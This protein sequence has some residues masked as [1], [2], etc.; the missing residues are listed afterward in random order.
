[1]HVQKIKFH[2]IGGLGKVLF[3]HERLTGRYYETIDR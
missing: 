1:L 2:E 3:R